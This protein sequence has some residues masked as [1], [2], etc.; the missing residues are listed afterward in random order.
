MGDQSKDDM[1]NSKVRIIKKLKQQ[2]RKKRRQS[3]SKASK[4][5]QS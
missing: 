5:R 2:R 1:A 4:P 3:G